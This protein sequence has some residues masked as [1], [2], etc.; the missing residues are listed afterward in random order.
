M[1][2]WRQ[3]LTVPVV[4]VAA[5]LL[6][7]PTATAD[8]QQDGLTAIFVRFGDQLLPAGGDYEEFCEERAGIPR[9]ENRAHV[10][11][12]LKRRAESSRADCAMLLWNVSRIGADE[13]WKLDATGRGIF[14]ALCDTGLMVTPALMRALWR[15]AE[16][17]AFGQHFRVGMRLPVQ[18]RCVREFARFTSRVG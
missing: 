1:V 8:A 5:M 6:Y 3:V 17:P 2:Q 14:V 9:S 16:M 10:V 12:E 18:S 4:V 13:A 15:N 7:L 11:A